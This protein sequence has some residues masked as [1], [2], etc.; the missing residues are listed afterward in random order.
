M[1]ASNAWELLAKAVLV[2]RRKSIKD[3]GS[4]FTI[5]GEVAVHRV[6]LLGL[7]DDNQED[8]VQ[9][10]ISLRNEACHH[11]LPEMPLEV[12]H[13]LVFFSCKFFRA[14][15][16]K[17][18]S[19]LKRR[20]HGH[21][22]SMSFDEMT[23]YA[24]KVQKLVAK[25]KKH[26]GAKKLVWLLER[27]VQFD[28]QKYIGQGDFESKYLR[29]RK[30]RPHLTL[31]GYLKTSEM[32][33]VVAVQAPR[34]Y[35]ADITLRKGDKADA[36]LPVVTKRSDLDSDYPYLTRD[37]ADQVGRNPQ[38]IARTIGFLGLK[39]QVQYHQAVRVSRSGVAHRYSEAALDRVRDY[40]SQ[41]P[42]FN[43]YVASRP[44]AAQP[45]TTI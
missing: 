3:P 41:N 37:I 22:L 19:S 26:K 1:L 6:R 13:H 7:L 5:S 24:D 21:Y 16:E 38:F 15:V 36:S 39:G 11:V 23:T 10:I 18:I 8:C 30:V 40:L 44:Q 2:K 31:N 35:T 4:G 12:L 20:L 9:Q 29:H 34:N 27:G 43:P 33:K 28:G 45:A 42:A 17:E 14:I 25:V 32:V